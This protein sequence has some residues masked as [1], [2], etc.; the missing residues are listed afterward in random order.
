MYDLLKAS[1]GL[2]GHGTGLVNVNGELL[3]FSLQPLH[4][5]FSSSLDHPLIAILGVSFWSVF[6]YAPVFDRPK[7]T[8][9][10]P[11]FSFFLFLFFLL[12][13]LFLQTRLVFFL[14]ESSPSF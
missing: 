10:S 5:L 2:I 6:L 1:E 12:F 14:P 8:S 11:S 7:T 9:P 13:H 3:F 4:P